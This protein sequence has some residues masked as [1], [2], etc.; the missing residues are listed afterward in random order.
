MPFAATSA[1]DCP[2]FVSLWRQTLPGEGAHFCTTGSSF[3]NDGDLSPCSLVQI[4]LAGNNL[5]GEIAPNLVSVL[6]DPSL[7]DLQFM[8]LQ[9]YITTFH[10]H[11][12]RHQHHHPHA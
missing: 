7:R 5:T 1:P 2:A 8:N 6:S 11:T 10:H 4:L 3:G 9:V 12:H